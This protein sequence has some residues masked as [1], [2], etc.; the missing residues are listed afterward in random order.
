MP[1]HSHG[2]VS[3]DH[4]EAEPGHT[5]DTDTPPVATQPPVATE[6]VT[7]AGAGALAGGMIARILFTILGAA[8][9]IVGAFMNWIGEG[10]FTAVGTE[11]EASVFFSTQ[12]DQV[13]F[14]ASA[15]FVVIVLGALALLGLA[16]A[17]GWLTRLAG[18]LGIIA[19]VLVLISLYRADGDISNIEIGLWLVLAGGIV[20]VIG[21]FF[22]PRV[23]T[24]VV[25]P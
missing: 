18:A 19:F 4:L 7:A 25:E 10:G 5:H 11:I 13:G 14:F 16:P 15:G 9:L 17:T 2:D 12:V 1:V 22:G 21:G 8:G 3:H 23:T 20:A 6:P 24:A